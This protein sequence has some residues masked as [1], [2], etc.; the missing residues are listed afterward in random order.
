MRE[1]DRHV[2]R[3]RDVCVEFRQFFSFTLGTRLGISK[4]C[5]DLCKKNLIVT[6]ERAFCFEI[7]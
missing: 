5:V 1:R 7:V 2:E 3:E 6:G 4:F